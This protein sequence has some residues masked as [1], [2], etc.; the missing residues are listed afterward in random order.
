M[1]SKVPAVLAIA[2]AVLMVLTCLSINLLDLGYRGN[3]VVC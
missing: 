1:S 2:N 3:D